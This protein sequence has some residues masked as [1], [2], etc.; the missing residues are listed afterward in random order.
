MET[1]KQAERKLLGNIEEYFSSG[2]EKKMKRISP[3]S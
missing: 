2:Q 1:E 3:T